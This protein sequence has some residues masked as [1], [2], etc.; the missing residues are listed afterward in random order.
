MFRENKNIDTR[1]LQKIASGD[2]HSFAQIFYTYHQIVGEYMFRL[3]GSKPVAQELVQDVFMKIWSH[4]E[5]LTEIKSFEAYL[6]IISRNLA[7]NKLKQMAREQNRKKQLSEELGEIQVQIDDI[8]GFKEIS[9]GIN[10]AIETLPNQQRKVYKLS[11]ENG[12]TH[13]EIARHLGISLETAKKHMVLALRH[14][15]ESLK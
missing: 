14:L 13:E 4:R 3:T 10:A 7:F 8:V 12:M 15:R 1:L 6:F 5:T 11:R 9:S 2:E